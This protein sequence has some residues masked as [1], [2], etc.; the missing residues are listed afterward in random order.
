MNGHISDFHLYATGKL[1]KMY[2]KPLYDHLINHNTGYL[3]VC[4]VDFSHVDN[5]IEHQLE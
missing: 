4:I 2:S 5:N 3:Q 1:K